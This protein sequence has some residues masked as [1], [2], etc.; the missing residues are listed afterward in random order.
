[1]RKFYY[2]VPGGDP[3]RP[4]WAIGET[5]WLHP[6]GVLVILDGSGDLVLAVNEWVDLWV[7]EEEE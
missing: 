2:N 5:V 6:T 7:E 4:Q 1:M 3:E